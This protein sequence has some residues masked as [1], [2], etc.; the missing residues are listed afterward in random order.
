[1]GQENK[2]FKVGGLQRGRVAVVGVRDCD[3]PKDEPPTLNYLL[4]CPVVPLLGGGDRGG[5]SPFC[6]PAQRR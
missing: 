4:S 2:Y 1:M 5:G 3:W 6:A